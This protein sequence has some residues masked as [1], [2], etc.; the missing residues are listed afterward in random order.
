MSDLALRRRFFADEIE[1]V[2]NLS[3]PALIE[4]LATVPRER[5]L[6]E[7]PWLVLSE[8]DILTPPR[9]TPDAHPR[10]VYHNIG[11]AIDAS[12]RLFNGMPSLLSGAIEALGIQPGHHVLHIGTGTGYYTALLAHC[13]GP[14]GRVVGIEVDADLGDRARRALSDLPWAEVWTGDARTLADETFDAVLVNAGVTHA[15]GYY[16]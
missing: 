14:T 11:I 7:G 10:R 1:A 12:R 8:A 5:F 16:G 13:T 6:G 15:L 4:A 2:A 3:S 9:R